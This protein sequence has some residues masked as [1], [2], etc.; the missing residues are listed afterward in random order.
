MKAAPQST[1][2]NKTPSSRRIV[3]IA[4]APMNCAASSRLRLKKLC[5][6]NVC[7]AKFLRIY[8]AH[9]VR[10]FAVNLKSVLKNIFSEFFS[11]S[12]LDVTNGRL[13]VAGFSEKHPI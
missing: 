11:T 7:F 1:P 13:L 5:R 9:S 12:S 4:N 6:E 8:K 10:S 3:P 2:L